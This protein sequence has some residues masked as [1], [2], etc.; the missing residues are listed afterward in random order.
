MGQLT[1]KPLKPVA[2]GCSY[3]VPT[4]VRCDGKRYV[5]RFVPGVHGTYLPFV[6]NNC[7]HNEIVSLRDRVIGKVPTPSLLGLEML[8]R[9]ARTISHKLPHT[10][11]VADEVVLRGMRGRRK[12]RYV[13]AAE[14][15]KQR[16]VTK[17]DAFISAFV[18]A[19]KLNPL[20]KHN[21]APRMIQ[22]ANA[23]YN[24]A[25]F[26][27]L[28]PIEHELY[29][30][31]ERGLPIV[32]KG[33]NQVQRA[34]VLLEKMDMFRDP[35]VWSLDASR[36]DQHVDIEVLKIE[37]SIYLRCN[38]DPLLRELLKWQLNIRG[39]TQTGVRYKT[40]GKRMSGHPN[41]ALGN[42]L[43]MYMFARSAL[44]EIGIRAE[45][46]VD[47]DDTLVICDQ[48]DEH[49]L[50]RLPA[51]FLEFG[52][53]LKIENRAT[54]LSDVNWCQSKPVLVNG[55]WQFVADYRKVLSSACAGVKYWHEET[56]RRDMA[57]S[58]GQCLLALYNGTP[59]IAAFARKLCSL[60][61]TINRDIFES[62]LYRKVHNPDFGKLE[63]IEPTMEARNSF[64]EAWGMDVSMQLLVEEDF[65]HFDIGCYQE[66]PP[67]IVGDWDLDYF[68]GTEPA[69]LL[70]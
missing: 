24:F 38:N 44:K 66:V 53:E 70:G 41:T 7:T 32:G 13:N 10:I 21:P 43:L 58:V 64:D 23:R 46:F 48:R 12:T 29:Q 51:I 27:F 16:P 22:A 15:L 65:S 8:Q 45:V 61:G 56:T 11:E 52:Q 62:D 37:H 30:I 6:H 33:L 68:P 59:V 3:R 42:C 35:V 25:L 28:K 19:E 49:Q 36:F 9:Q 1:Q 67:E 63:Y 17:S 5:T 69:Q 31:K 18:K 4:D 14:S 57:F 50:N 47:G 26:K 40:T 2:A 55:R 34:E 20:A 54:K 60:G 39:A